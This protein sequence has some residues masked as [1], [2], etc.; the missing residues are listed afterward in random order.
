MHFVKTGNND[1]GLQMSR[2]TPILVLSLT[3]AMILAKS[4]NLMEFFA[5]SCVKKSASCGEWVM[6]WL[7][8]AFHNYCYSFSGLVRA[9][10]TISNQSTITFDVHFTNCEV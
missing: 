9:V 1:I 4:G 6:T 10:D 2:E 8:S 5:L 3:L 7:Y